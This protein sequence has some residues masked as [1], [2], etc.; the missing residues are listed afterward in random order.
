MLIIVE[1]N[2]IVAVALMSVTSIPSS[3]TLQQYAYPA[4]ATID[5][6]ET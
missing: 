4:P 1:G 5:S 6:G 3:D 2:Y